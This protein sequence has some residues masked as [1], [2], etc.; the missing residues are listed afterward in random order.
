MN[1]EET[2]ITKRPAMAAT[3][4]PIEPESVTGTGRSRKARS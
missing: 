4:A 1:L 2:V 3:I